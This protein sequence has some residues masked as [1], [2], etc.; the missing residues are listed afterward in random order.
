MVELE[1]FYREREKYFKNLFVVKGCLSYDLS[2]SFTFLRA[3]SVKR[4]VK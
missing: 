2:F 4:N 1:N 3:H